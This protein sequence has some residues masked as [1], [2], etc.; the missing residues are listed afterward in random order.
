ME[1]LQRHEITRHG[2]HT[3]RKTG[4]TKGKKAGTIVPFDFSNIRQTSNSIKTVFRKNEQ[5][6]DAFLSAQAKNNEMIFKVLFRDKLEK[7]RK[8]QN[9]SP[10][11]KQDP[12]NPGKMKKPK[13]VFDPSQYHNDGLYGKDDGS[14]VKTKLGGQ[15]KEDHVL[16][17]PE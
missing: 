8:D 12:N 13:Y 10:K 11:E 2:G 5:R 9:P 16:N 3:F 6:D 15:I 17:N 4:A 1:K 7:L 14:Q